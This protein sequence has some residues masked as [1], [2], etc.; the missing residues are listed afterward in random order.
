MSDDRYQ[1]FENIEQK[2]LSPQRFSHCLG[3]ADTA[4]KLA[5]KYQVDPKK[6]KLAGLLHDFYKETPN[7]VFIDLIKTGLYDPDLL[8]YNRGVWHGFL[9]ADLLQQ[10]YQVMDI[11][12][13]N[14][15]RYHTI[16][17]PQMDSLAK[18]IFVADYIEPHRHFSAVALARQIAAEDLDAAV[19]FEIQTSIKLLLDQ[20]QKIHPQMLLTYNALYSKKSEAF[21]LLKKMEKN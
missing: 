15:I 21:K 10:Q 17:H 19:L 3:V 7:H 2:Q 5:L 8:N 16:S 9:G 20:G 18:I 14:A 4:E 11:E 6:A 12:I 13:L 1:F